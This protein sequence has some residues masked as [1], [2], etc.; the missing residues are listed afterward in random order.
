VL[1]GCDDVEI[2]RYLS[3]LLRNVPP[4]VSL[5]TLQVEAV[6]SSRMAVL[7][8]EHIP[9]DHN[10]NWRFVD[11][12]QCF[13]GM[14]PLQFLCWP[15]RWRQYVPLDWQYLP[16]NISQKT[17]IWTLTA[18]RTHISEPQSFT[19]IYKVSTVVLIWTCAYEAPGLYPGGVYIYRGPLIA[20]AEEC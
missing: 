3:V 15:W 5:L 16:T 10:L 6:C 2:C 13:W 20:I 19:L 9:E 14:C 12:Y 4:S 11:M 1:L 17:I 18:L 7:A 8:Y